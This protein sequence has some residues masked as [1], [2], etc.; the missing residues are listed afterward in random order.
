[1]KVMI[2]LMVMNLPGRPQQKGLNPFICW[3]KQCTHLDSSAVIFRD[4]FL[5]YLLLSP[6]LRVLIPD[7]QEL[8]DQSMPKKRNSHKQVPEGYVYTQYHPMEEVKRNPSLLA[9]LLLLFCKCHSK[10]LCARRKLSWSQWSSFW[11][12]SLQNQSLVFD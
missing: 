10:Q 12:S 5:F 2:M 3:H 4:C 8:V 11:L 9:F 6:P 1:M 7:V